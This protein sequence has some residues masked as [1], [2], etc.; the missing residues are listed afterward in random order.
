MSPGF[1]LSPYEAFL[2]EH[3][4]AHP[5]LQPT[6]IPGGGL[7]LFVPDWMHTKSLGVDANL[8]GSCIAYLARVALPGTQEENIALIWYG[9]QREYRSQKTAGRLGRLTFNMVKNPP[10]PRLSAKANEIMCLLP[11]METLLQGWAPSD[12]ILVWFHRLVALS[13]QIDNLVFQNKTFVL[14]QGKKGPERG[15]FL[16]Q[17]CAVTPC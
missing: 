2:Q 15:H 1:W 11:V 4:D 7:S 8:L 17:C 5:V 13:A 10:F 12:P 6:V 16:V 9:I 3:P 14:S